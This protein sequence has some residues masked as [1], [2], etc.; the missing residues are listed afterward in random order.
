MVGLVRGCG[1]RPPA[2]AACNRVTVHRVGQRQ[3]RR[4]CARAAEPRS[5]RLPRPKCYRITPLSSFAPSSSLSHASMAAFVAFDAQQLVQW[6]APAMA[7]AR[8]PILPE[9]VEGARRA[10][11]AAGA[12]RANVARPVGEEQRHARGEVGRV[13]KLPRAPVATSRSGGSRVSRDLSS[14]RGKAVRE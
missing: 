4:P 8:D 12:A 6:P 2:R 3:A 9:K 11:R 7:T 1:G 5:D 10:R 13:R 14:G